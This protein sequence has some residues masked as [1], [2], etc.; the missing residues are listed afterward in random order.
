[1]IGDEW[2]WWLGELVALAVLVVT[3]VMPVWT[4]AIAAVLPLRAASR[5]L[6]EFIRGAVEQ[7]PANTAV[8]SQS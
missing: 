1:M 2:Y 6:L 3:E 4:L 5:L 8:R 7:L